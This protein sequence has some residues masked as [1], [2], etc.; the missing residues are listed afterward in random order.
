MKK[1]KLSNNESF[2]KRL[3]IRMTIA[4]SA[5]M[6]CAC[7]F[8][9]DHMDK[10]PVVAEKLTIAYSTTTDAFLAEVPQSQG[11]Y[12][13]EGLDVTMHKHSYGKP[14][15]QEVLDGKA[16]IATVAETPIMFS[17]LNGEKIS[18]IAT[19]QTGR[20]DNA[21]VAR[22]NKGILAPGD[23][24]GKTIAVTLGTTSDFFLDAFLSVRGIS[25]KSVTLV[26]MKP[27]ELQDALESGSVDAV[28]AFT[29][30][31]LYI[32]KKLGDTAIA[33]FDGEIYTW[34]FNIVAK[35]EFILN[36]PE[37]IKKMLRAIIKAEKFVAQ[38]PLAAQKMVAD[39]TRMDISFVREIWDDMKFGVSLDQSLILALEDE[40]RWAI[41][42]RL[43]SARKIPNYLDFIYFDGLN[44][45]KP[46][47]VRI[48]R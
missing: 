22:K 3:L 18:I 47:A 27:E 34:T 45:I 23:L 37:K 10:K 42:N 31:S 21:I 39:Y 26:N 40:S 1:M 32:Q 2:M 43:T 30:W 44:S 13:E 33:F 17:I 5:L 29:P 48:L 24:R 11:Y 6:I 25:K 20:K 4:I 19:I 16:D 36:N 46:E 41:K 38:N 9:C 35:Q 7:F 28:S 15:L 8:G 12:Q 14:A